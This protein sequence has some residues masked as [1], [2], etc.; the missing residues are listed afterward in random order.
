MLSDPQIRWTEVVLC[1]LNVASPRISKPGLYFTDV[2]Q[3]TVH[4][5]IEMVCAGF[6]KYLQMGKIF[7][8]WPNFLRFLY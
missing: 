1:R 7:S 8:D 6:P 4:R 5:R 2:V 3:E